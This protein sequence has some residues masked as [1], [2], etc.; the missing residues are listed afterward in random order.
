M[1]GIVTQYSSVQYSTHGRYSDTDVLNNLRSGW[2]FLQ[3]KNSKIFCGDFI[4]KKTGSECFLL[5]T[6]WHGMLI[7]MKRVCHEIVYS[8]FFHRS[9]PSGKQE[10]IFS[11]M[12][13]ILPRYSNSAVGMTQQSQNFRLVWPNSLTKSK[14]IAKLS[15]GPR[16]GWLTKK[17]G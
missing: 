16:W 1:D 12:V 15:Q 11:N 13:S 10:T 6:H 17:L 9:I 3:K 7:L 8:H 14:L 5:A 4:N 2:L